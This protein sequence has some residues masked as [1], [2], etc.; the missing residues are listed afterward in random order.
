M[1]AFIC[2]DCGVNTHEINEYYMVTDE[3]WES[4]VP[5]IDGMLCIGCLERRIGRHLNKF[6]F[7]D[8]PVNDGIFGLSDRVLNRMKRLI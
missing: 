5:E 6:D 3:L 8:C 2:L 7:I 4:A 1:D